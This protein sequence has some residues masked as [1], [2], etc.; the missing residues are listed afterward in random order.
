MGEVKK[1][2]ASSTIDE[3]HQGQRLQIAVNSVQQSALVQR[4]PDPLQMG[5][6]RDVL[7]YDG[8]N[9]YPNKIKSMAKRSQTC[10]TA[11][12][13]EAKFTSGQGFTDESYND[14]VINS[15]DATL[16]D[17]L[18]HTS[19]E[20]STFKG[21]AIHFNYNQFGEIAEIHEMA[22]ETLRINRELTKIVYQRSWSNRISKINNPRV[23]YD[24][25]DP[26]KVVEQMN[27]VGFDKYNG[28]VLYWIPKKN[29]IYTTCRFDHCLDDV[30]FEHE[31]GLY[32]L[33]NIQN[34]YSS[35]Y[36][37]K[38]PKSIENEL[39][40]QNV[41]NE[42]NKSRGSNNAGA[43]T[44]IPIMASD[45][46]KLGSFKFIEEIPRTGIDKMFTKQ[47]EETR[48]NIYAAFQQP[49]I[50]NGISSNGMFNQESFVD[51]FDFYNSITES[52]RKV[53]ERIFES[54]LQYSIWEITDIEIEPLDFQTNRDGISGEG[55]GD[56]DKLR[57]EAQ[58]KLK[59]TVGGVD[60]ILSI[61]EKVATG[62]T[63]YD[64]GI[65]ILTTIYGF[66]DEKAR[67]ILGKPVDLKPTEE[68]IDE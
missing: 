68:K 48:F 32:K 43:L 60:G 45:L 55:E 36:I 46:E 2:N 40:K 26:D 41:K 33:R 5:A 1:S 23:E 30:Q 13:T 62:I 44:T 51:A 61:Q 56:D 16:K 35:G 9:L 53:I 8:D 10:T 15:E 42:Q 57:K 6:N 22:F 3:Q 34:D 65:E 37:M 59:G 50:L 28:Q 52:G 24:P 18:A 54:F 14:I 64:A 49:P 11:I 20:L 58:A 66:D 63:Q 21:V 12:E 29:E 25:F 7:L 27:E 67:Q 31:S 19:N 4:L 47:N 38:Y 39:E 17:L